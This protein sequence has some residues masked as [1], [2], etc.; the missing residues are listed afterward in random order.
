MEALVPRDRA[1][2]RVLDSLDAGLA[3]A[4]LDGTPLVVRDLTPRSP[5]ANRW[6]AT[7]I[8]RP[9]IRDVLDVPLR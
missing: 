8:A 7:L 9:S 1:M 3:T 4:S 5:S 2:Q 6:Y